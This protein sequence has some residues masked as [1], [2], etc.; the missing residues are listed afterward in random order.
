MS[1]LHSSL[2]TSV[3]QSLSRHLQPLETLADNSDYL[4]SGC[5]GTWSVPD[6]TGESDYSISRFAFLGAAGGGDTI[7]IGIL[8]ALRGDEPEGTEVVVEF[9][10]QIEAAPQLAKGYH[11]YAYPISNPTGFEDGTPHSREGRN[12]LA[13]LWRHSS[14]SEAIYL[15]RELRA[16]RF[17]GL[18]V[19][20]GRSGAGGVRVFSDSPVLDEYIAQPAARAAAVFLPDAPDPD[21]GVQERPVS[22][23]SR[24]H[25]LDASPFEIVLEIPRLAPRSS[26]IRA[27]VAALK[28]VLESHRQLLAIGTNL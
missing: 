22:V 12:L 23:L 28:T 27:S 9:L 2:S 6:T 15:E 13:E 19:L 5:V 4:T 7:R 14:S 17:H 10:R 3:R 11:V 8:A 24:P 20:R 1:T 16:L 21:A 25:N 18:I 26:R